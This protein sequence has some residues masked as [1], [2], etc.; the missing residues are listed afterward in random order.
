MAARR[1]FR[2]GFSL[3]LRARPT[4]LALTVTAIA[5]ALTA[6]DLTGPGKGSEREVVLGDLWRSN[7]YSVADSMIVVPETASEHR[8]C[9][10]DE[11]II[12]ADTTGGWK[13]PF[14]LDGN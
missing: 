1:L 5:S 11:L 7:P 2:S 8:Y 3:P 4:A 10:G 9:H 12:E 6:C 13:M 14:S